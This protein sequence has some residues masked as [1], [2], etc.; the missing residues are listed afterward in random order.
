MVL[1][2]IR[3]SWAVLGTGPA[4]GPTAVPG[5]RPSAAG[6]RVRPRS[7]WPWV[8]LLAAVVGL[9]VLTGEPRSMAEAEV[10]AAVV[11]L[12]LVLRPYGPGRGRRWPPGGVPRALGAGRRVGGG[13]GRGAAGARVVVHQRLPAGQRE[14]HVL[15]GGLAAAGLDRPAAGPGPLRRRRPLRTSPPTSTPTTCPRSPATSGL[16][17]L[18]A[19]S[20]LATRCV[21]RRRDPRS[22][23]WGLWLLLAVLGLV[24]AWGTYTPL[25]PPVRAHPALR[26]DPAAEPEPRASSTSPWPCCSASG[27]TGHSAGRPRR[28]GW[29]AG[30]DGW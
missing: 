2:Q 5:R 1:A 27:P 30:G 10:V 23:D 16:L 18:V 15:R 19:A 11:T 7:P 24:L 20:A 22:A 28:P 9:I 6:A 13:L 29:T 21:G 17:P 25:G 14:L 8:V 3:L 4:A 26:Q 12:W